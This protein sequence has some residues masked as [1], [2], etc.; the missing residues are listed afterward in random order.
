MAP[1]VL[2][3]FILGRGPENLTKQ[4]IKYCLEQL[5]HFHKE[6]ASLSVPM[7]MWGVSEAKLLCSESNMQKNDSN[8]CND[9][10]MELPV[11]NGEYASKHLTIVPLR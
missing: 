6:V 10:C 11:R 4:V 8:M 1:G 3:L 9:M 7:I 2:Q 5:G